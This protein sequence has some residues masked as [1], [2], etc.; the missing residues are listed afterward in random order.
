MQEKDSVAEEMEGQVPS[1]LDLLQK[2]SLLKS[3]KKESGSGSSRDSPGAL[4][5]FQG[6]LRWLSA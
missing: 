6:A 1:L 5:I 3:Q 2:P 4:R